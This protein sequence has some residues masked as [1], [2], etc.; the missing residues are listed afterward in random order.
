L[1]PVTAL[2]DLASIVI[3]VFVV[4]VGYRTVRSFQQSKQAVR[5]SASILAVIVGALTSRIK[6]TELVVEDVRTSF[7]SVSQH[8]VALQDQQKMLRASYE[9]VLRYIQEIM[10]N[11]KR[12]ILELEEVKS[13]LATREQKQTRIQN[14]QLT[15]HRSESPQFT[16][17]ALATLTP[18]ERH[19]L[20]I[21][22]REGSKAAPE[23]GRRM[24][25]SR[26]HM[27]RLMKKL[28]LNGYVDRESN[29]A[30]FRYKLNSKIGA[31]LQPNL[32]TATPEASEKS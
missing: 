26:E 1:D 10:Y 2:L 3:L 24:R 25:K 14:M 4:W 12:M 22:A 29:H 19:A 17:D 18:T 16:G 15:H 13:H 5:E 9:Q 31:V 32:R 11:D 7:A 30:P 23:L 27:A 8:A 20:E 28:Y 21:L 6:A